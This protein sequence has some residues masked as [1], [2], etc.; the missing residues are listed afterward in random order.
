MA[1][2]EIT[3]ERV[4]VQTDR[5]KRVIEADSQEEA[6]ERAEAACGPYDSDCPDDAEPF[7][8]DQC[9]SWEVHDL[10][11]APDDAEV[12]EIPADED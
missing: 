10:V 9:E 3:F 12:D 1:K 8:G 11:P 2:F 4:V 5:F 6:M 7:G